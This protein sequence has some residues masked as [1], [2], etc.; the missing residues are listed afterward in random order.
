MR[1][2]GKTRPA[3]VVCEIFL[4]P[5]DF[6]T[7]GLVGLG[8]VDSTAVVVLIF[9]DSLNSGLDALNFDDFVLVYVLK[10]G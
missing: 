1:P 4:V 8:A 9:R 6:A 3:F 10:N 5:F 2:T 7:A